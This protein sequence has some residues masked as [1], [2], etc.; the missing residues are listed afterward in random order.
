MWKRGY[1]PVVLIILAAT[2]PAR[3]AEPLPSAAEQRVRLSLGETADLLAERPHPGRDFAAVGRFGLPVE[4]ARRRQG[5]RAKLDLSPFVGEILGF[6]RR[7][8]IPLEAQ[9]DENGVGPI[10]VY[11]DF[12]VGRDLPAVSFHLGD[13]PIE[14]IGAF[15]SADRGF[16]CALVWPIHQF[17]LRIEGGEDS[18]FGYFGIA[19]VQWVHPTLPLAAGIGIPMNLDNSDSDVGVIFQFRMALD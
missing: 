11:A 9:R 17:T 18:E 16:R 15:Y 1:Q 14:P 19:G 7:H 10:G 4:D 6:F 12:N 8:G 3:G 13:K 2:C 5:R